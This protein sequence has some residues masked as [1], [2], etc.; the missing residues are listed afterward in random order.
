VFEAR[1][2]YYKWLTEDYKNRKLK[3]QIL[4]TARQKSLTK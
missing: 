2:A 4:N 3:F 1:K